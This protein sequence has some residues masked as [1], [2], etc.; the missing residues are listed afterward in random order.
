MSILPLLPHHSRGSANTAIGLRAA[1]FNSSFQFS[2]HH[3]KGKRKKQ[4]AEIGKKSLCDGKLWGAV[5]PAVLLT[6]CSERAV[7]GRDQLCHLC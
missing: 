7:E 1:P 3:F 5:D 2:L 6:W 4:K